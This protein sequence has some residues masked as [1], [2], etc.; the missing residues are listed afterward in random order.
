MVTMDAS[1]VLTAS[2]D[3]TARLFSRATGEVVMSLKGHD[4]GINFVVMDDTHLLTSSW[5]KTARYESSSWWWSW[6]SWSSA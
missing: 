4:G 6:W 5:D 2:M 3:K 1:H